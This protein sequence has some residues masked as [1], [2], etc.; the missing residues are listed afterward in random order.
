[1]RKSFMSR[2]NWLKPTV[3]EELHNHNGNEIK[4]KMEEFRMKLKRRIE[5]SPQPIKEVY[6]EELIFLDSLQIH[7]KSHPL[8]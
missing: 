7:Q 2:D 4:C 8:H 5:H 3:H 1:M 6:R